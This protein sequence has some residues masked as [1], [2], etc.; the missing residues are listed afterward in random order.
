MLN[1]A[2]SHGFSYIQWQTVV[3]CLIEKDLGQP[4]I[5]RLRVINLYENDYNLILALKWRALTYANETSNTFNSGQYGTRPGMTAYDL[6]YI[7][8]LQN[9]IARVSRWPYVKFINCTNLANL[10]NWAFGMDPRINMIQGETLWKAKYKLKTDM[11]ISDADYHHLE[12]FPIYGTGQGSGSSPTL[13]LVISSVLFDTYEKHVHGS[14]YLSPDR[15]QSA[16]IYIISF[17][18]DSCCQVLAPHDGPFDKQTLIHL[19]RY[20][21]QLWIDLLDVSGGKLALHKCSYHFTWYDFEPS[22][23]PKIRLGQF[24]GDVR[25]TTPDG[26]DNHII[27]HLS[28]DESYKDRPPTLRQP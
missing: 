14:H 2:L 9:E 3:N 28:P 11:R 16:S 26:N 24:G 5:H 18:D 22:G 21:A 1:Y 4:K 8:N 17:V 27:T 10:A 7:Q 20:D 23:K 25:L 13:W 19:I 12:L 6:V 15:S